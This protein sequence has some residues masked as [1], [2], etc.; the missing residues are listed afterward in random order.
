MEIRNLYVKVCGL[1]YNIYIYL[2]SSKNKT[3]VKICTL[4]YKY[5][6]E[7]GINYKMCSNANV[8]IFLLK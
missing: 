5:K 2:I 6:S 8:Y 4:K 1:N 3:F 7:H